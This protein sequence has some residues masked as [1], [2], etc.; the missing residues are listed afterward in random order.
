MI[1]IARR[2]AKHAGVDDIV[3]F[4]THDALSKTLPST[5]EKHEGVTVISNPPYDKRLKSELIDDLH[6]RLKQLIE[7]D[8]RN[9][10]II[11]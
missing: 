9:G 4:E 11:S 6:H 10:A 8:G 2:N 5:L 1:E 7:Q 3:R